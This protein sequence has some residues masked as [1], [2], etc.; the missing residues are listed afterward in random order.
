MFGR[1]AARVLVVVSLTFGVQ[2]G[3]AQAPPKPAAAQQFE[4]LVDAGLAKLETIP[5][6]CYTL[7]KQERVGEELLAPQ[8][9]I[10]KIRH[11]PFSVYLKFTAPKNIEGKEA[12]YVE[13][14]ND[15]KLIGRGVGIQKLFG[16][17][18]LDP[19]SAVAMMGNR[20][21][22]T[23]SGMKNLLLK[24]KQ[25]LARPEA[26]TTYEFVALSEEELVDKRPCFTWQ[27]RNPKPT[28]DQLYA[29]SRISFDRQWRL[30]VRYQRWYWSQ[31]SGG[32]ELLVEDYTYENV[33]FD[34]GLTDKDFD[35]ENPEYGF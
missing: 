30:P 11:E 13:G 34:C 18:K 21:P 20:N 4:E 15:G 24:L 19:R 10:S 7:R 31:P 32:K 17:Q 1:H 25:M 27:V 14:Q 28:K 9:L 12:I 26:A 33:K 29:R 5:D 8:Q 23:D 16:T 6:Y 3:F 22:I 2:S 35:P